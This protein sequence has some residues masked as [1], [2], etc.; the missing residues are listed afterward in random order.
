MNHQSTHINSN[1]FNHP[2]S[3]I[4]GLLIKRLFDFIIALASLIIL[5]PLFLFIAIRIK[6][7]SSGPVFYRG[8]RVGKNGQIF[9]IIKFRTMYE[10]SRSN[11]GPRIT[12]EDDPRITPYG[13]TLRNS[14]L[15]ELPQLWNV[16]KGEM[17]LVG[18][19]PEDPSII[20]GW[21][22]DVRD[23][24]LSL[25]PGMTSPTS[26]RF[27]KEE[28]M[29]T[30]AQ[31]MDSYMAEI[32][33]NKLRLDQLYVRHRSFWGDL[34]VI[35]WTALV[36]APR[37]GV[38][39][40]SD[41]RLFVGPVNELMRHYLTWFL[42]DLVIAFAAIGITGLLWRS[43]GPLAIG[44]R[45]AIIFAIG[46][47]LLCSL[48][49]YIFGVQKISWANSSGTDAIDLILPVSLAT[50]L[51]LLINQ[52]VLM[53]DP[54]DE[55]RFIISIF[56]NQPL[57][58][59]T[60][61]IV[62]AVLA[63]IGFVAV[64]YRSRLFTGVAKRWLSWRKNVAGP[65]ER[66]LIV[67]G[68][69][70]GQYAS[71]ILAEGSHRN[72]FNVVGY[73]DDDLFKHGTRIRGLNVIGSLSDIPRLVSE[74]DIGILIF[75]IHNIS[76]RERMEFLNK[77]KQ[78]Q[79]RVFDFP[80]IPAALSGIARNGNGGQSMHNNKTTTPPS[81]DDIVTTKTTPANLDHWL[82]QLDDLIARGEIDIAQMHLK[83]IRAQVLQDANAQAVVNPRREET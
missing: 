61:I 78:T 9:N 19:R 34:D 12:A 31:V 51:A 2:T 47:A 39:E 6:R 57:V 37:I 3:Q 54:Q 44:W 46:F 43:F 7:D 45:T 80:D 16:L 27:R 71:W 23:E 72:A 67:G 41:K 38:Y 75:A 13:R 53:K 5:S 69:E 73:V 60:M 77:C 64:R 68:G 15:N 66:V 35:F 63:F 8:T 22:A 33:P 25:R 17:S 26:V 42:A 55:Y 58:P 79:A 52:F 29:L 30:S 76:N 82:S 62:A 40:P 65:Q 59:A 74:N 4:G 56:N 20:A 28:E 49:G 70:T 50:I 18:P 10:D 32:L 48:M 83:E 24:I 14:K 21:P 1:I 11:N 81:F 36:L